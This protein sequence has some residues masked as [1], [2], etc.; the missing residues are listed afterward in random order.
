MNRVIAHVDLN[1]FFVACEELKNPELKG[2]PVAIGHDNYRG[3]VS[4]ASYEARK[5]GVKSGMPVIQARRLCPNLII[6][7]SDFRYY[8]LLSR[9]FFKLLQSYSSIIEIASIDE[10][11][12]DLTD[13]VANS[14]LQSFF[15]KMQ[16]E[17][18]DKTGLSC[19]IGVSNNLFLA[20]MASDMK[21]P[22]GLTFLFSSDVS[23][24]LWPLPIE[25]MHG[26][27]RA[28]APRLRRIG[29]NTIGDLAKTEPHRLKS[30]LGVSTSY[31]INQANGHGSDKVEVEVVDPKSIGNSRTF[32]ATMDEDELLQI[33]DRLSR[34]VSIRVAS[35]NFVGN[36]V[37]VTIRYQDFT[38]K[39]RRRT[40]KDDTDS[41]DTII[42][43]ARQLFSQL[44]EY[45]PVRLLGVT[46][47]GLK[48][49]HSSYHQLDFATLRH[50]QLIARLYGNDN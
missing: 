6:T 22:M 33:L 13:V 48:G 7:H 5:A 28:S 12:M 14:D 23:K 50:Q 10:C 45:K 24:N 27:G 35:G 9:Q 34:L 39:G 49:K 3:V 1:A 17:I 26:I 40:L 36:N 37:A 42:H 29:I 30:I 41:E 25:S 2:K 47:G 46:L 18:F 20:K 4:T 15:S 11:Y 8:I 38:T 16:K 44:Y 31:Y 43:E 32:L 19:S 21:K